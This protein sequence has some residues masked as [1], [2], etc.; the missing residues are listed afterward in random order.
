MAGEGNCGA[1]A[2]A[3]GYITRRRL[4]VDL[5]WASAT[6]ACVGATLPAVRPLVVR[7]ESRWGEGSGS[8]RATTLRP[9]WQ[10]D[11]WPNR[12]TGD[13]VFTMFCLLWARRALRCEAWLGLERVSA[14]L[15]YLQHVGLLH[16]WPIA[17]RSNVVQ[18]SRPINSAF[19]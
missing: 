7:A 2:M 9:P 6:V 18:H 8:K 15:C 12:G 16:L 19:A 4:L 14:G 3:R 11:D 13:K 1:S 5:L 17:M 10:H